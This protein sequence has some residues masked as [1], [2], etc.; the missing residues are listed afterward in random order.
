MYSYFFICKGITKLAPNQNQKGNHFIKFKIAVP[1]KLN[2][3]EKKLYEELSKFE[4]KIS[5]SYGD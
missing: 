3:N 4:E 2:E 5:Q 1:N